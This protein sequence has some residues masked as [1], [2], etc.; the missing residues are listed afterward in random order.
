MVS[1]CPSISPQVKT[2][3]LEKIS[4]I[5]KGLMSNITCECNISF[6]NVSKTD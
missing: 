5:E 1:I 2:I 6:S 4:F 3:S